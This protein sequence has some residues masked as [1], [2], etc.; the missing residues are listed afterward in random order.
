MSGIHFPITGDNRGFI[1]AMQG[2]SNAVKSTAKEIEKSGLEIDAIFDK[3]KKAAM[4]L[5][6]AFGARELINNV[7]QIRGQFQQLEVAFKTMLGSAEKANALM[8][9]LTRTAAVT[10]FGLQ[11]VAGGAKQLLAYGVAA[12][13]V[14]DT[15]I[16]LGDIAAGLSI[17][18]GDLVYLYGTTITQGRMFTMDLRQFQGR[19]IPI[20]EELAKIFNVAKSEVAGLVSTGQVT[21]EKFI[22]AIQ[23][24][25]NEG[26][27]FGG[28]MSEQSKTITGQISNIEDAIDSMFNSIGQSTEGVINTALSGV[29]YMV[30][31]YEKVGE[32]VA[33]V[34]AG[35]GAYKAAL[36]VNVAVEKY[37]NAVLAETTRLEA[38]NLIATKKLTDAEIAATAKKVALKKIQDGLTA[39]MRNFAK[40]T[41]L[42]PYVLIGTA[43][44]ALTYGIYKLVTAQSEE[45]KKQE[46]LNEL[47][48]KSGEEIN[49]E[50]TKLRRLK[51]ELEGAEKNSKAYNNAKEE[52]VKN[53][54]KYDSTLSEEI[55]KVGLTAEVYTK[56]TEKINESID[57][58]NA[59]SAYSEV[60][61]AYAKVQT[62]SLDKIYN[63]LI[64]HYGE[65]EG[66]RIA[67][68]IR[69]KIFDESLSKGEGIYDIE[70]LDDDL[71]KKISETGKESLGINNR[72]IEKWIL[73]I[74][75]AQKQRDADFKKIK[76]R[77]QVDTTEDGGKGGGSEEV[78]KGKEYWEEEL[79]KAKAKY[80]KFTVEELQSTDKTVK[81][82][83]Q[84]SKKEIEYIEKNLALYKVGSKADKDEQ[85]EAE[86]R[87]KALQEA[88]DDLL[89]IRLENQ[90]SEI[91][92]YKTG[93]EKK[94]AIIEQNYEEELKK[95]EDNERKLKEKNKEAGLD[96]ILT[97]DQQ[98][99]IQ[100]SREL[101]NKQM[102]METVN[103]YKEEAK[104]IDE[105][106]VRY[107]SFEQQ[108]LAI[109]KLYAEKIRNAESD[110]E[111]RVLE[112]ERDTQLASI[113]TS[114][115]KSSIDWSVIFGEF[116][117][118]FEDIV[119]LNLEKA[120][121]YTKT[122][123]FKNQDH[124]SQA[125]LLDAIQNLKGKFGEGS[126]A[127]YK[128]LGN[129]ISEYQKK[130]V[131][132]TVTLQLWQDSYE[133]LKSA[134]DDYNKAIKSGSEE[135]KVR[136]RE[137]L[138]RAQEEEKHFSNN[139]NVA[140]K[141]VADAKQL[142]TSTADNLSQN[143]DGVISGL[144]GLASADIGGAFEN[145]TKLFDSLSGLLGGN[146]NIFK[147]MSEGLKG[148]PIVGDI[149][150]IVDVLKDG[151]TEVLTG[152]IEGILGAVGNIL[153]DVISLDFITSTVKSVIQ[154]VGNILNT[155]TFGIFDFSGG[156]ASE[157][158]R[159]IERLTKRNE[160][161]EEAINELTEAVKE[162]KG[163][164]ESI[165]LTQDAIKKQ[166]EKEDNLRKI[167]ENQM[168]YS[169][170]HHSWSAYFGWYDIP[171]E[172]SKAFKEITGRDL[173][174]A[175]DLL[176]LTPEQMKEFLSDP[177]I[178]QQ[179]TDIG[180]GYYGSSV[181]ERLQDYANEAGK[182]KE[183]TD[184]LNEALTNISFDSLYD[185]F[186]DTL[187]DM[188]ATAE[189]IS[190]DMSKTIMKALMSSFVA[191]EMKGRLEEW[192]EQFADFLKKKNTGEIAEDQMQRII[193]DLQKEYQDIY[194]DS[195]SERDALAQ[196]TGYTE[197]FSQ[198]A[199]AKGFSGMSQETA[200]ELNGRFT[201][202]QVAG[203]TIKNYMLVGVGHLEGLL[204]CGSDNTGLLSQIR[205]SALMA[206]SYLEDIASYTK[207]TLNY[208]SKLDTIVENTNRL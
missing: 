43:V 113:N 195:L 198:E 45:E 63:R 134:Q 30:E 34:V 56:L 165:K 68:I 207:Q 189:D 145:T 114:V 15:L 18:L 168:R 40:A 24:M 12:E 69:N 111:K 206:N 154:G 51:G 11:D 33:A 137:K 89:N 176:T 73:D 91:E 133:R 38:M 6:V 123:Q 149:L 65:E 117:Y 184:S 160:S 188:N 26:S 8:A 151:L 124:D 52:L 61:Q 22:Q 64:K 139:L 144:Q 46:R 150:Q 76:N 102:L 199:S 112:K 95:I 136:A 194:N 1:N 75:E 187:M 135:E 171:K 25:T 190:E 92:V 57:A 159:N 110:A 81:A 74:V 54:S 203:E 162:S 96:Y 174:T 180:K 109:T 147:K 67:T 181:L 42:N 170:S 48:Q 53:F 169:S 79:K 186:V 36:M 185:S 130:L 132:Q 88:G 202:L 182:I 108:K 100:R 31:N 72:G 23:N 158:N 103:L 143:M 94:L 179:I 29:S 2:C 157:I 127:T 200:D 197:S 208:C 62:V 204:K 84:A 60:E 167:A 59:A 163:G 192:Y 101:A 90:K 47:Y 115:L 20:A 178:A 129:A 172:L 14:N 177:L 82:K 37:R 50:I 21:S 83:V 66:T 55:S 39:S 122:D 9:Q 78:T 140:D 97:E 49:S 138:Q 125:E 71:K 153:K 87:A 166:Q 44:A 16:R 32:V 85:K 105:Y 3:I 28:L 148:V 183:L 41:L 141:A 10:P 152:L 35:Y 175:T 120:I 17:P 93:R 155:L 191:N 98:K 104:I 5:G 80:D 205:D 126:G 99:E 4:G 116:G 106:L 107:G 119:K 70:G 142:I 146:N 118:M 13:D 7:I 173:T 121:Q 19:G 196:I 58:R 161:L 156:N 164:Y 131:Q 193:D 128:D 201:A 27:K 77:F 86:K